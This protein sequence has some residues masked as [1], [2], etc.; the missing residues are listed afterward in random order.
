MPLTMARHA[1]LSGS[2]VCWQQCVVRRHTVAFPI[3]AFV[4]QRS[5]GLFVVHSPIRRSQY[6][7]SGPV[8][9]FNRCLGMKLALPL[10]DF[11]NYPVRPEQAVDPS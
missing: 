9:R 1:F 11:K 5:D 8:R 6:Y 2:G 3:G 4:A 10:R 7:I